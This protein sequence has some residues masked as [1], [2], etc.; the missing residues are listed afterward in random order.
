EQISRDIQE[1]FTK[2]VDQ[3]VAKQILELAH[4]RLSSLS[5]F[6]TAQIDQALRQVAE[7]LGLKAGPCFIV[8]RIAATGKKVTPPL[9]ESLEALGKDRAVS[10]IA[11]TLELL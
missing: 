4:K 11:E 10:R 5:N 6:E 3:V 8:I 7:E 2:G 9:F 1:M